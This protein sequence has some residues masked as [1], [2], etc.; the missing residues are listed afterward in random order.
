MFQDEY[1]KVEGPAIEQLTQLG[2][3]Y[4]HGAELS[5]D[6]SNERQYFRDRDR[7]G[8]VDAKVISQLECWWDK[9][10]VS[11]YELDEQVAEAESLM[12][13]YLGELGYE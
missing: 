11:L 1:D 8:D 5:P 4:V 12:K 13:G 3:H 9:Y 6:N 10:R 2:W 7:A